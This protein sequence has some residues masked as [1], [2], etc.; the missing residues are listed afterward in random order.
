MQIEQ[1]FLDGLGH[2][3]YCV[4]RDGVA[5][6]V[7][8]RRDVEIYL[9]AAARAGASFTHVLETHLHN[10]YV[11]GAC[12]LAA[13]TGAQIV[14]SAGAQPGYAH[15]P[16]RDGDR[17]QTGP[18]TFGV[19]YT[20]GHTTEHVSYVLFEPDGSTPHA[21]FS[22]GSMLVGGAGR[23][24]LMGPAMTET[25]TRQQYQTLL[26]LL[27]TLP[28][29]VMV[30]P[31]H[32]AGSFCVAGP[33]S[34]TRHS[35][36]GRERLAG[37]A[38]H[39]HDEDDFV[40]RQEAGYGEY[41]SYYSL[42]RPINVAGP[43]LLA[44]VPP[45][46]G[47]GPTEIRSRMREGVPLLDSRQRDSF[48]AGHVPASINVELGS[49]F[50]TY[51]GWIF[52][53]NS[54]VMLLSDDHSARAESV[55]QLWR[56]GYEAIVGYMD[57]GLSAWTDAGLPLG[58]FETINLPQLYELWCGKDP[59][60]I[61]DVRRNDE[62]RDGR[63]PDSLHIHAADLLGRADEVPADKP[64]AVIC[65]SGYR[66]ETAASILAAH[67]RHVLAVRGGVPDWL[68]RGWPSERDSTP[69]IAENTADHA[70]P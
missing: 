33:V 24:D 39:A 62:W 65:A 51:V 26:K 70:H 46:A 27:H 48:A 59:L 14:T 28:D 53:F 19:R 42:M 35:T 20:P 4:T 25:L 10:D 12:E 13:R 67:G 34:T 17:L 21:I 68:E 16:V 2:Q 15:V 1:F 55:I 8:P 32:G 50:G 18:L 3:S 36:I 40:R 54:P 63:I 57:G 61:L 43:R 56:I 9:E 29:A 23:T 69:V 11:T 37:P 6:V 7:D 30:Y 45:P 58:H 5:V 41:P 66:A 31:T 44:D 64:I 47:L 38:A 60:T 22:G 52:P 49:T